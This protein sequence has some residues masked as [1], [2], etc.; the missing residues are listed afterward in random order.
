[1]ID[2]ALLCQYSEPASAIGELRMLSIDYRKLFGNFRY[3][4]RFKHVICIG[5][6]VD[7][8]TFQIC[9]RQSN[10]KLEKGSTPSEQ[11]P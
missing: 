11:H 6:Q 1:V 10:S 8:K 2:A 7:R 4:F 3:L 9:F 5:G